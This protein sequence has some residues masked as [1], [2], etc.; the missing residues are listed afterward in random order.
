MC[1]FYRKSGIYKGTKCVI[2]CLLKELDKN[3]IN[4]DDITETIIEDPEYE[5][6]SESEESKNQTTKYSFTVNQIIPRD[7]LTY[8]LRGPLLEKFMKLLLFGNLIDQYLI[9]NIYLV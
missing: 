9:L 6:N 3:I 1:R 5:T 7:N 2:I 4:K 8:Y